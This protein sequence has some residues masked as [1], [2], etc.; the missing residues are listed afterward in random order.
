MKMAERIPVEH[1]I[2]ELKWCR[3]LQRFTGHREPL[4]ETIDAVAGLVSDRMTT[5]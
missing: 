5:W 2:A 4:P 1:A 3:Q